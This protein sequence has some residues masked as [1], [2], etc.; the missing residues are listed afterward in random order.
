MAAAFHDNDGNFL[1]FIETKS[2]FSLSA[3]MSSGIL[4]FHSNSVS[5]GSGSYLICIWYKPIGGADWI[6]LSAGNYENPIEMGI[7]ESAN[8][9]L[10]SPIIVTPNPVSQNQTIEVKA[11]IFNFGSVGFTGNVGAALFNSQGF[12]DYLQI[13]DYV[14][15]PSGT[16]TSLTFHSN[17]MIYPPGTYEVNIFYK[18]VGA[19]W[20]PVEHPDK[21]IFNIVASPSSVPDIELTPKELTFTYSPYRSTRT[22]TFSDARVPRQN[23]PDLFVKVSENDT[24][25]SEQQRELAEKCRADIATVESEIMKAKIEL[26]KSEDAVNLNLFTGSNYIALKTKSKKEP[27]MTSHGM[28]LSEM[29][30]QDMPFL[31]LKAMI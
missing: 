9:N 18:S 30:D 10:Y 25:L 6:Q 13:T 1:N 27:I 11:D 23:P 16:Q 29:T 22:L 4:T 28:A 5:Y 17:P 7:Q 2:N 24:V 21:A 20:K 15:I 3:G 19:D 26:L 31:W 12:I 8:L 14:S